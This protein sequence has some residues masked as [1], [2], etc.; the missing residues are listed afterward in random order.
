MRRNSAI[1]SKLLAF[2]CEKRKFAAVQ[3]PFQILGDHYHI[4]LMTFHCNKK[5]YN[6]NLF[7]KN[8][9][10]LSL[11]RLQLKII[12]ILCVVI[13]LGLSSFNWDRW[14]NKLSCVSE[15]EFVLFG[16]NLFLLLDENYTNIC[17]YFYLK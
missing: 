5:I 2:Y 13:F 9:N 7:I 15:C 12:I 8:Y 1:Y 14:E 16:L 4:F 11:L 3:C 10:L 6:D 17:K